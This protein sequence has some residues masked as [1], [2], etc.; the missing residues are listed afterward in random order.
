M[1]K[2]AQ[3]V[4]GNAA[5]ST[6]S[7]LPAISLASTSFWCQTKATVEEIDFEWTIERLAF[8]DE[9]GLWEPL[10]SDDFSNYIKLSINLDTRS[11]VE[12]VEIKLH[13]D[14]TTTSH[15]IKVELTISNEKYKAIFQNTT[16]IP[17]N[18]RSPVTVFK[19]SKK[20]L[21]ESGNFSNGNITIYC[22]IGYL[23]RNVLRG[24]ATA[25]DR[26]IHKTKIK[27][28]KQY[29]ILSQLEELFKKMPLSDATFNIN[30]RK[31]AAHKT[32]LAMRSEVFAAMFLHPTKEVQ[33]GE[34][35][36]DDI[37]PDVFQEVLRYLYTGLTRSTTMDIMAPE[38]LAAA[39]KYMLDELKTRC[40]TH[41]I[42]KM[43]AK[44]CLDLL[45]LTAHH[46]A[47]HLKK[48]AIEYFRRYPSKFM[49]KSFVKKEHSSINRRSDYFFR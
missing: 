16:S 33:T 6:Q 27:T 4:I 15:P 26:Y 45:T 29:R 43:S 34:V 5:S 14:G 48:F 31:F 39:D 40:E 20:A 47:E 18:T 41:L 49:L 8:F 13:I 9:G 32:I 25:T 38:L 17:Q 1:P 30:G 19:V 24:K 7:K 12:I 28:N 42:R 37:D 3:Q 2:M 35:K 44:N 36:V 21:L 10:M 46:P 23:K 22:K 11:N